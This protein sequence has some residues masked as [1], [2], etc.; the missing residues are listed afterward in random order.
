MR[1]VSKWSATLGGP[2]RLFD[3]SQT[4]A[5][6]AARGSAASLLALLGSALSAERAWADPITFQF[7]V[8][9]RARF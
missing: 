5:R 8:W 3:V 7:I 9:S 2:R 4:R 1:N 6:I